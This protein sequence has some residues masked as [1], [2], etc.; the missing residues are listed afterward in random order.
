M[1]TL[2]EPNRPTLSE[3]IASSVTHGLGAAL[4]VAALV[5]LVVLAS[6]HGDAWKIVS[7]AI[8][9][10]SLVVLYSC[11]TLYHAFPPGR[12][13]H[14]FLILDHSAIYILI[15]GSYTPFALVTLRGGWGWALFGVVWGL[16]VGGVLFKCFFIHRLKVL[17][18]CVYLLMGWVALVALRPLL[19]ALPLPGFLLLLGGGLAYSAGVF[20]YASRRRF[21]HSVWHIFVLAGSAFHFVAVLRYVL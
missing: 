19:R 1:N 9:G 18:T 14:F 4:S 13:K 2:S 8:F 11:S 17:S 5:V 6:L 15:A 20:F 3:E 16:A 21:A 10:A 12:A 7:V